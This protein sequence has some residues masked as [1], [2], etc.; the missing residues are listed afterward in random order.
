MV[1]RRKA[2]M[3]AAAL[4]LLALAAWNMP[5]AAATDETP[6]FDLENC[7]M[8]K[9]MSAEEGLM[10]NM[11]WEN[12]LTAD[13]MMSV[14]VVAPGYEKAFDK[15]M[16]NMMATGEK[17]KTGN[18]PNLCGF[19]RSFGDLQKAGATSEYF[20]TEA[21]H[22]NL[23]TSRDPAVIEKIHAHGQKT[24]D[25]YATMFGGHQAGKEH[26]EHPKGDH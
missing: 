2:G 11:H 7:A 18:D 9:H 5:A 22:I 14:T 1:T 17:L 6:W 26:P 8:C 24:I 12:H 20:D 15:S 3:S 19:C 10:E 23:V 21:G 13:G 25:E 16:K 4:A